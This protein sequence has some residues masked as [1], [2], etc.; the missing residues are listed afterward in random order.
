MIFEIQFFQ[1][2][3]LS[4]SLLLGVNMPFYGPTLIKF[5]HKTRPVFSVN[6]YLIQSTMFVINR[7]SRRYVDIGYMIN[8]SFPYIAIYLTGNMCKIVLSLISSVAFL[9]LNS[10]KDH[11]GWSLIFH[12]MAAIFCVKTLPKQNIDPVITETLRIQNSEVWGQ[13]MFLHVEGWKVSLYDVTS[14]LAACSHVPSGG[15]LSLVPC[16]SWV[17]GG[18]LSLVPCSF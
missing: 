14:C 16:S 5:I 8:L 7:L 11:H 17:G 15:S 18:S 2:I 6:V 13:V 12:P 4:L 3:S 10:V 9:H 1:S